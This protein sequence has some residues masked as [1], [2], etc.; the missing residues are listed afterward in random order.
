METL[1]DLFEHAVKTYP[2]RKELLRIRGRRGWRTYTVREF[3]RATRETAAR[4]ARAGVAAGERVAL[5][6]ENRPEWHVI[7][8]ACH[9]IAA[10]PVPLYATLPASQVRYIVKDSQ[11]K[12]LL[13]SGRDRARTALEA[14]SDLPGVRVLGI[15]AGLA[16]G[17]E[18]L[19]DLPLP[20]ARRWPE[21]PPL[22]GDDLAS[23]IYTSGTTG[24]PKGVMLSHRNFMSQVNTVRD[25]FPI[26]ERDICMSFLPLSHVFERTVDYVFFDCGS[27]I[28]YVE[29]IERVPTQLTE[30][31]P[32]IMVSVPRLYERSYIKIISKVQQEGGAKRRL[33]E[34]ALRVGRQVREAEWNGGRASAFA[35]GQYAVARSRV[36]S[37]VLERL[38]GR[39]RFSISGGAPLAREVA[40][41][42]DVVGLPIIQGY[43]LTESAPVIAANRLEA[44]RL[45]S[46]GQVLPGVEVR[47]APDGEILARGPN[48]ML[49]YW[50]RPEATAEVVDPDGWLH[51]GDVG[52][53]DADG[54]LFITDRK[55]DII[56]TSGGKNVAPQ[57]I[58]GRLGATPYIAQA[59]LIGDKFPYLTALVVPNFENLEAHFSEK[60]LAGLGRGEIA[61]HPETEA[62][63]ATAVKQ[64]NGELATH[65][66]IRRFTVL[67]REL[68]LEDGEV[69]PTLKVR[70]R[71]V[72]E[73]YAPVI[74]Q[75]YLK[76]Q[77]AGE[78]DL[79]E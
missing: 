45:G 20:P 6:S 48:I 10:V 66:R 32:T 37:K 7:D 41:F 22:S 39:L 23:L 4:L 60:G 77:R 27:Q 34:W 38:G 76:T 35:R 30:I 78:Y 46:V 16:D 17:L 74:E 61:R 72:A 42:F 57:P 59:V 47:I 14:C 43:G 79:S 68:S 21:P 50:A 55:K 51:T 62:L 75:M 1:R 5:F 28:N 3:E 40:A 13:V 69:T 63:V 15:D 33:F 44:N 54:Y 36:F 70:R 67:G 31:R 65:E 52:Y 71:V 8:F 12:L 29:S 49:G 64:V 53:L 26:T 19:E 2:A 11:S 18:S 56:V 24:E 25:L 73:R 58:E 9:L